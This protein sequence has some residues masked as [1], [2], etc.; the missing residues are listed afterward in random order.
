MGMQEVYREGLKLMVL[1]YM[2]MYMQTL[3]LLKAIFCFLH[4]IYADIFTC[5]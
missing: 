2:N 3:E 5:L 4:R 1:N